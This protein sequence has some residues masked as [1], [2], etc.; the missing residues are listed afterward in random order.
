MQISSVNIGTITAAL[1]SDISAS[2]LCLL[3]WRLH[4]PGPVTRSMTFVLVVPVASES[5][6][7][8][9]CYIPCRMVKTDFQY[10]TLMQTGLIRISHVQ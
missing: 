7:A 4:K 1:M 3:L 9:V 2:G 8:N 5:I 10:K 6:P